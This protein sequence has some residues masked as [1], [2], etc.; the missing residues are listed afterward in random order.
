MYKMPIV[1][2]SLVTNENL[3]NDGKEKKAFGNCDRLVRNFTE[4]KIA[5]MRIPLAVLLLRRYAR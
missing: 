5:E 1:R 3:E 2:F 4:K